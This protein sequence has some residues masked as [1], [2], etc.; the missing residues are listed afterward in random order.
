VNANRLE[1]LDRRPAPQPD[2]SM[3]RLNELLSTFRE[4]RNQGRSVMARLRASMYEMQAHRARLREKRDGHTNGDRGDA[5]ELSPA[6]TAHLQLDYGMT[7]REVDVALLL[8]EGCSNVT[9]ARRLGIS[10][11]TARHHTQRVLGKLGVHSRSEAGAR[12]RK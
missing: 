5:G 9:V 7:P 8:A 11:H 2:V 12:L 3:D 4:L 10:P 6:A 1:P